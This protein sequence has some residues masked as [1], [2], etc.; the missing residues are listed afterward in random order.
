MLEQYLDDMGIE[1]ERGITIKA[2]YVTVLYKSSVDG[3]KYQFKK[4][5]KYLFRKYNFKN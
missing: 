5:N 4:E 3:I 2:H 1:R